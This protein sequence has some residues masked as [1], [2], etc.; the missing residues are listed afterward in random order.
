[1]LNNIKQMINQ[2]KAYLEEAEMIL[3][4]GIGNIDDAI[5][6]GEEADDIPDDTDM[7]E[8]NIPDD[9]S[10]DEDGNDNIENADVNDEPELNNDEPEEP[11]VNDEPEPD[12]AS[13]EDDD[14]MNADTNDEVTPTPEDTPVE[15]EIG[16]ADI[17]DIPEPVGAQTG[18]PVADNDDDILSMEIDM[19]SNTPTDTLPI[20]P[21]GAA[22]AIVSDDDIATQNIDSGFGNSEPDDISGADVSAPVSSTVAPT[23]E[24]SGY[25]EAITIDG[26]E[27]NDDRGDGSSDDS[28][29]PDEGMSDE[30]ENGVTS[31]VRDK[32]AEAD[33]GDEGL[34]DM[35]DSSDF[36]SDGGSGSKDEIFKK[37]SNLTKS[38]EDA[39]AAVI[40]SM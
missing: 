15:D 27:G 11:S 9:N 31:A 30:G 26:A 2:Q 23:G 35:D 21:A 18:E 36:S 38:L 24:S 7:D 13:G 19:Q 34:E 6:L 37:L 17:N 29:T 28:G 33:T 1:M 10:L 4:D 39:K 16:S 3:E 20:P 25:T 32:V 22:G 40:K 14:I 5:V 8:S 12:V